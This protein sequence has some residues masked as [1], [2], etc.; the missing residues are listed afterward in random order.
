MDFILFGL[1]LLPGLILFPF[2]S[3]SLLHPFK[4]N[5]RSW[6]NVQRS[7]TDRNARKDHIVIILSST[8]L[9]RS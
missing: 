4:D 2:F 1:Y 7:G 5:D 3:P 6:G 8:T 9:S